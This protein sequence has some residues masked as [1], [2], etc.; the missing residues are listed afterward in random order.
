MKEKCRYDAI[1]AAKP[2]S[3]AEGDKWV[4]FKP[5]LVGFTPKEQEVANVQAATLKTA[6][7]FKEEEA[8]HKEE[9]RLKENVVEP[10]QAAAEQHFALKVAQH[11]KTSQEAQVRLEAEQAA[12]AQ[13]AQQAKATQLAQV[14]LE[15][16][17]AAAAKAVQRAKDAHQAQVKL[18][19]A[20]AAS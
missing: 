17:Q 11:A 13:A 7:R 18:R 9:A 8:R 16:E 14:K 3:F 4:I 12:T 6:A 5:E 2:D 19:A 10:D 15:T 20:R 1:T